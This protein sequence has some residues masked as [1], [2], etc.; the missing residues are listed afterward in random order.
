MRQNARHLLAAL[1]EREGRNDQL[2]R[3]LNEA[4]WT[5]VVD[6]AKRHGVGALLFSR[7]GLPVP[8]PIQTALQSRAQRSA[9]LI[10][11]LQAACRELADAAASEGLDLVVLKGLHLAT[12]IY[13]D[14]G[15][16]EMADIDI[17]VPSDQLQA[18][19]DLARGLGYAVPPLAG[20]AHH[21]LPSMVRG[22][23]M[24]EIHWQLF[25]EGHGA[26]A[27]PQ[28]IFQ[29]AVPIT[30]LPN[31]RGLSTEDLLL[32]VCLHAASH[33][34]LEMGIRSLCDVQAIVAATGQRVNW[35][36]VV[37]RAREWR[38]ERSV[39]LM[40]TLA[41]LHLGVRFPEDV[42]TELKDAMPGPDVVNAATDFLVEDS[43][44]LAGTSEAARALLTLGSTRERVRHTVDHLVRP[45]RSQPASLK[46]RGI[47]RLGLVVAVSQR[48]YGLVQRHGGWLWR[49]S[50]TDTGPLRSAL[51]QRNALAEWIR[52]R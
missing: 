36:M 20:D 14:P 7:P 19:A 4:D 23:V 3:S 27:T 35:A 42:F 8:E 10:L 22:R 21:H 48:A 16:R 13:P 9:Q 31:T 30:S 1:H 15:M 28:G 18:I 2:L 17:L 44:H 6:L 29:R 50:R 43:T 41:R 38:G 46:P 25:D 33:H 24:L 37:E 52:E 34:V 45:H 26:V 40:C 47:R 39:A 11:M 12:S 49:A 51:K 32:H 5:A